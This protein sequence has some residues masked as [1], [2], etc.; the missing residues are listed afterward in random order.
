[1]TMNANTQEDMSAYLALEKQIT[2]VVPKNKTPY[3]SAS[4]K[5]SRMPVTSKA[6]FLRKGVHHERLG[7]QLNEARTEFTSLAEQTCEATEVLAQAEKLRAEAALIQA[8]NNRI[9]TEFSAL[10]QKMTKQ[11]M[12]FYFVL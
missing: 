12:K 7:V 6:N 1:M 11:G 5:R 2:E 3:T 8:E 4:M 9:Q 10:W